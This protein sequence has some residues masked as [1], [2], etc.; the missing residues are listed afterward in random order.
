MKKQIAAGVLSLSMVLT[1]TIPVWAQT[2]VVVAQDQTTEG[3]QEAAHT[4]A[5]L[6]TDIAEKNFVAGAATEF[7]VTTKANDDKDTKVKGTY[8][9][10]KTEG[11][12]IE[13]KG[14]DGNWYALPEEY[15]VDEGF[16]LIDAA[17]S[18]RATFSTAGEYTFGIT[19][20]KADNTEVCKLENVKVK[21]KGTQEAP[22]AAPE[23]QAKTASTVTLK[24]VTVEGK[25][26]EYGYR[27]VPAQ[28]ADENDTAAQDAQAPEYTWQKENVFTGLK[29]ET[30]YAFVVRYA[31]TDELAA[32]PA[33][34]E[35]SVTTAAKADQEAAPAA[36][37]AKSVTSTS[38]TLNN[39]YGDKAVEYGYYIPTENDNT[40]D[41]TGD[42]DNS[43][44]TEGG[45]TE[46]GTTEG[47]TTEGGTTEGGTTE[48]GSTEGGTTEG[49]T[50]EGGTTEGG[51]TEGGTT[52]TPTAPEI[53]WQESNVFS[54][55]TPNTKYAFVVRYAATAELNAS[56]A[57]AP[58]E[59]TTA[60]RS[61]SYG[62]GG[63]AASDYVISVV[64]S[65]NGSLSVS[66]PSASAG[67]TITVTATA[68]KG[69]K[70]SAVTAT[71]A[72]G[73]KLSVKSAGTD[74]YTFIM[75]AGKVSVK[76][77]FV[78][79]GVN[80]DAI[81]MQIGSKTIQ[82]YGKT[83]TNDASPLIVNNR[84]MVPIRVVTE[85][86]GGTAVWNEAART[87][88]LVINGKT[89][90]MTIDVTL[91]KY[92]VAPIIINNRTYVPIRFV[93]EEL[94][95]D[96]QWNETTQQITITK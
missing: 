57:S 44:T 37:T 23:E 40:G 55:L 27:E 73:N 77:S 50:I 29:A 6:S 65:D 18:F 66:Q 39:D 95:A 56:G 8:T 7:T 14:A 92:G 42:S 82:A 19:L 13:Y 45:T 91:E 80:T 96:V 24:T 86:L 22:A 87:V 62:G 84:T 15:G 30:N 72:N 88:T 94:G 64:K 93:A 41:N 17:A 61:T 3:G 78:Q 1:P 71:D 43:G 38:V 25:T 69:Y 90:T 85:T 46:G 60:K 63:A 49:G 4:A 28:A 83:I 52:E 26:V 36:P 10:D 34:A 74:K 21:V 9:L 81:I 20:K 53:T 51:T 58:L 76:A 67:T 59:V 32:S 70:V 47:G 12:S 54:G 31:E 89:I 68:D 79:E 33:S 48:G 2:P 16:A 35:L 5:T 11:V 75:P